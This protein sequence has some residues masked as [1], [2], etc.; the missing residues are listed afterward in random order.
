MTRFFAFQFIS[1][2]EVSEDIDWNIKSESVDADGII[3]GI[4]PESES[5]LKK[6]KSGRGTK[7]KRV[8]ERQTVDS[9]E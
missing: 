4:I 8:A 2:A 3:Y 7:L 6:L 5:Q 1:G 9:S